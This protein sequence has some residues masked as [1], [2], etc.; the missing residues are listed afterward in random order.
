MSTPVRRREIWSWAFYDFANSAFATTILAVIFAKYFTGRIVPEEGVKILG[1]V[2]EGPFLW[3]MIVSASMIW[4]C[5]TAPSVGAI[6]DHLAAKKRFLFFYWIVGCLAT[7]GLSLMAPGMVVSAMIIFIVANISFSSANPLYNAFLTELAP[8][9][10]R[11]RISSFGWGIGYAGGGLCLAVNLV[12]IKIWGEAAVR[13]G[14]FVVAVWW[15]L[16]SL[17]LFFWLRERA[18]PKERVGTLP[19]I[20]KGVTDVFQTLRHIRRYRELFKFL[21]AFLCFNEGVQT[22]IVNAAVYGSEV[23]KMEQD[24]L[25]LVYLMVQAVAFVGAFLLGYIADRFRAKPTLLVA[26]LVWLAVIGFA[27]QATTSREFWILGAMVGLVMGGTQAISR[28]FFGE[29]TPE[30]K[31]AEFF[32]FYALGGRFSSAIGPLIFGFLV[33]FTGGMKWG[34]ASQAFFFIAGFLLLLSVSEARGRKEALA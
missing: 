5:L 25:I 26:L 8:P 2:F 10:K 20:R 33:H 21:L 32:G 18:V 16:F 3:N 1:Q 24:E 14:F 13:P 29:L 7:A 12:M 22:I 17:P 19:L 4:V 30:K 9:E 31:S 15:F 34:I 28:G 27:F 6:T 23:I 11:S